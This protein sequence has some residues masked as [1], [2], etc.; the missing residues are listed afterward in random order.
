MPP[1]AAATR[2]PPDDM[3]A[4]PSRSD[5][6]GAEQ[7]LAP[8]IR[9]TPAGR[10]R[11]CRSPAAR[12][13]LAAAP[14]AGDAA[15]RRLVQ[16]P[17]RAQPAPGQAA[18][19]GCGGGVRRQLRRGRGLRRPPAGGAGDRL[20]DRYHGAC[21]ARRAPV[22]GCHGRGRSG[23]LRRG[24]GRQ[25]RTC[26]CYR[27]AIPSRLRPTRDARGRRHARRR[28]GTAGGGRITQHRGD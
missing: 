23:L 26:R 8:W 22:A 3:P 15:A 1:D 28:T 25:P 16:G 9:V 21:Q 20:R 19:G 6:E 12:P 11:R 7:R 2:T 4:L 17:G 14:Q 13:A 5:I 18:G 24:P 10:G 27:R